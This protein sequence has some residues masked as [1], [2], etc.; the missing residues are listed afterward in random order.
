MKTRI[1]GVFLK[2]QWYCGIFLLSVSVP[3]SSVGNSME[4]L[5][6]FATMSQ[7]SISWKDFSPSDN[8]LFKA[9]IRSWG[10]RES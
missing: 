2:P 6:V 9:F 7:V 5:N 1:G 4:G 10:Y 3:L 8:H